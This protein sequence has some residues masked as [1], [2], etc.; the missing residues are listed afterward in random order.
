MMKYRF[1]ILFL[2]LFV[3]AYS[4]QRNVEKAT[5]SKYQELSESFYT[6]NNDSSLY[7]A[8]KA[9]NTAV[10]KKLLPEQVE[11]LNG[12][13]SCYV[14][15]NNNSKAFECYLK[16]LKIAERLNDPLLVSYSQSLIGNIYFWNGDYRKALNYYLKAKKIDEKKLDEQ[17]NPKRILF[18]M[19]YNLSSTYEK[20][21]LLDS[22]KIFANKAY[23]I[24]SPTKEKGLQGNALHLLGQI[25]ENEKDFVAAKKFYKNAFRL[26]NL[27]K[28]TDGLALSSL[29]LAKIAKKQ[30][31]NDTMFKYAKISYTSSLKI[32]LLPEPETLDIIKDCYLNKKQ[33]DSAI[34]FLQ[35]R[36]DVKDIIANQEKIKKIE[37]LSFEESIREQAKIDESKK[38]EK[39]RRYN[40]QVMAIGIFVIT[41]I[42]YL[43][44]LF[45]ISSN[46][47]LIEIVGFIC[48]LLVF[49][50]IIF[51]L[52]PYI[53]NLTHHSPIFMFLLL[54]I[55]AALLTPLHQILEKSLKRRISNK[56]KI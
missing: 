19:N 24:I 44:L 40:M 27:S 4:Q 31:E 25:S 10:Q 17:E 50:F 11:C 7:Y 49:E 1:V 47:K 54:L 36:S 37:N 56:N 8:N 28:N 12:I 15:S 32:N 53:G 33:L 20:L 3:I 6:K 13:G 16:S 45:K 43:I 34:Y 23:H 35:K 22:A 14:I 21:E 5:I 55:V 46:P 51:I 2:F 26:H 42:L 48:L 18:S 38:L 52:H 9:Y 39:E 29:G 30:K 41:L